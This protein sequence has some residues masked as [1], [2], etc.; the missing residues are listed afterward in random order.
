MMDRLGLSP[1]LTGHLGQIIAGFKKVRR[2]AGGLFIQLAGNVDI[3]KLALDVGTIVQKL[4]VV[5]RLL[6]RLGKA[7]ICLD[8]LVLFQQGVA[9]VVERGQTG[10]IKRECLFV[11]RQCILSAVLAFVDIAH[12]GKGGRGCGLQFAGFV[13]AGRRLVQRILRQVAAAKQFPQKGG[14]AVGVQQFGASCRGLLVL[15]MLIQRGQLLLQIGVQRLCGLRWQ[16]AAA[17]GELARQFHRQWRSRV[18][19]ALRISGQDAGIGRVVRLS[20]CRCEGHGILSH[21]RAR[22]G[23]RGVAL[24]EPAPHGQRL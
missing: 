11:Q 22:I 24:E 9:H 16:A 10:R 21:N 13:Q 14:F 7:F 17:A 20:I 1:C 4:R 3:A 19:I 15:A 18:R 8:N 5:W 2:I 6:N 23:G 12:R